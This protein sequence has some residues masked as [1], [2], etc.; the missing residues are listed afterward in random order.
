MSFSSDLTQSARPTSPQLDPTVID[1]KHSPLLKQKAPAPARPAAPPTRPHPPKVQNTVTDGDSRDSSA[2]SDPCDSSVGG[3][4]CDGGVSCDPRDK[5]DSGEVGPSKST[6]PPTR[7]SV[8]PTRPQPPPPRP[9]SFTL[10]VDVG[11]GG[12]VGGDPCDRGDSGEGSSSKSLMEL[13]E[14]RTRPQPPGPRPRSFTLDRD[15]GSSFSGAWRDGG[16]R[17]DSREGS[18]DSQT[19]EVPA[20]TEKTKEEDSET[21]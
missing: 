21:K 2:N 15:V 18:V 6:V 17:R 16:H 11:D 8:P 1:S 20:D 7:P 14:P 10:D 12:D 3:D 19:R 5:S 13:I 9:R 4:A